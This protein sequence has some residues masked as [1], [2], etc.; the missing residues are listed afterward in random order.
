MVRGS[1]QCGQGTPLLEDGIHRETLTSW[2]TVK[3]W[4]GVCCQGWAGWRG[5][6]TGSLHADR[7]AQILPHMG[8]GVAH[9]KLGLGPLPEA[10]G[11]CPW[12]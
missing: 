6:G 1:H 11:P 2:K 5:D 4:N 9:Y 3:A 7:E 10:K 8:P 12:E